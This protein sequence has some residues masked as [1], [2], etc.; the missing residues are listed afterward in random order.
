MATRFWQPRSLLKT[1]QGRQLPILIELPLLRKSQQSK[2]ST[3][4]PIL[5]N[6]LEKLL[7][8]YSGHQNANVSSG[9][10]GKN[11]KRTFYWIQRSPQISIFY[12]WHQKAV[13]DFQKKTWTVKFKTH[14]FFQ[15]KRFPVS[16]DK[17]KTHLVI[18]KSP[19]VKKQ[20]RKLGCEHDLANAV[21]ADG[22]SNGI[23]CRTQAFV[24]GFDR[25]LP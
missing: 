13:I 7:E 20:L 10:Q 22:S 5:L 6:Q 15:Q 25:R 23:F 2:I 8:S 9:F 14:N 18:L 19:D 11:W 17:N 4:K 1:L 3:K 21:L 16:V 12:V 24:D